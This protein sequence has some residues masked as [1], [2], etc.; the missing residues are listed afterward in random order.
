MLDH[1]E[2]LFQIE[3]LESPRALQNE[4]HECPV[5]LGPLVIRSSSSGSSG[6]S[7]RSSSNVPFTVY[8]VPG[9]LGIDFSGVFFCFPGGGVMRDDP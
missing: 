4:K 5:P 8:T 7:S 9:V 3:S 1:D 6:S 2:F